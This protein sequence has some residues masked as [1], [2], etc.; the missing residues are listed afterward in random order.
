[1]SLISDPLGSNPLTAQ[2][3][4]S[5]Q[6]L[7]GDKSKN[8]ER[9][10]KHSPFVTLLLMSFG[11]VTTTL[12]TTLFDFLE[13]YFFTKKYSGMSCAQPVQLLSFASPLAG[14]ILLILT[15]FSHAIVTRLGTLLGENRSYDAI[16]FVTDLFK[17]GIIT[18]ILII[19]FFQFLL[20]PLLS[21]MN[22]PENMIN[23]AYMYLTI[24]L[25][26]CPLTLLFH[27]SCSFLQSI[28][29]PILNGILHIV[30]SSIRSLMLVPLFIFVFNIDVSLIS[31]PL[32]LTNCALGIILFSLI[33][34]NKFG[35][36]MSLSP[37]F[38]SLSKDTGVSIKLSL[39][40]IM[41]FICNLAPPICILKFVL[42]IASSIEQAESLA[43]I[44]TIY[45]K[46]AL[47]SM[48]V[49]IAIGNGFLT[50]GTYAYGSHDR[51]RLLKTF[52]FTILLGMAY[53]SIFSIIMITKPQ[54]IASIYLDSSTDTALSNKILR[55][56]FYTNWLSAI[57]FSCQ[58]LLISIGKPLLS[59]IPSF[60]Q[61]ILL[62]VLSF[63]LSKIFPNNPEKIY[64]A[65]NINDIAMTIVSILLVII[66][67]YKLFQDQKIEDSTALLTDVAT[68]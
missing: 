13:L 12:S 22:C 45:G 41:T 63:S 60:L 2:L 27:M 21:F 32:V 48:S 65:Y 15:F 11:P 49:P 43:G 14:L 64:H 7:S 37:W 6:P 3:L 5:T 17:I 16:Q 25:A 40:I 28:G 55:I 56:P 52:L 50:I 36:D 35:Y 57:N 67:I 66:P 68:S 38:E 62:I 47:L 46:V 24:I 23:A 51:K 26:G 9:F 39:P 58:M 4:G 44:N 31:L 20:T 61:T 1:M 8:T 53:Q 34:F 30:D 33:Y 10:T 59:S 42:S 18:V 54:L 29:R 19:P